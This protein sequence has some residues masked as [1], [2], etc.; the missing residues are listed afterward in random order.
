M[1]GSGYRS[2]KLGRAAQ[3]YVH[4]LVLEA[5]VGPRPAGRQAA[6]GDGDKANNV[7]TNLR[8]ATRKENEG[9]KVRHG[10]KVFG[11]RT[12]QGR[13]THCA[14]GHRFDEGNTR[15][16]KRG[17]VCRTCERERRHRDSEN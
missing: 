13:K 9:D 7:V 4:H 15:R 11:A 3:V 10:T 17:R 6:H 8:W 5:F 16:T 2:A 14:R 1:A 12:A